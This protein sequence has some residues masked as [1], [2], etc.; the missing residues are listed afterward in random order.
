MEMVK[1]EFYE[2]QI[3]AAFDGESVWVSLNRICQ[4]LG[5]DYT[6]QRRKLQS[7]PTFSKGVEIISTP[8]K[9]GTQNVCCIVLK[10]LP[11]WLATIHPNKVKKKHRELLIHY[12]DECAEVLNKHFFQQPEPQGHPP[13]LA[14]QALIQ[15]KI[16]VEHEN[17]LAVVEQ[18]LIVHE[19][20]QERAARAL[21]AL[22]DPEELP[23]P[24]TLRSVLNERM[25]QVAVA[26]EMSY[27]DAWNKLYR[28]YRDRY[29]VDL[30]RRAKNQGKKPLDVATDMGCMS[31]LYNL[32]CFLWPNTLDELLERVDTVE[33]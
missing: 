10:Y 31:G 4:N 12:Q 8:T 23:R 5:T 16:L 7:H 9:G 14:Q 25:R 21:L 28:E 30:K 6:G 22:P 33:D 26:R 18:R 3:E 32:A 1:V 2:Q 13:T 27:Q 17:R 24:K 11:L 29:Q 20:R 19:Q 15:A